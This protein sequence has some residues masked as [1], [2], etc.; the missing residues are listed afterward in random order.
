[1][2]L[3][4]YILSFLLLGLVFAIHGQ[5]YKFKEF[6]L[7]D[8]LPQDYIYCLA[9][10]HKGNLVIGTGE[11]LAIFNSKSFVQFDKKSGLENDFIQ[12]CITTR[13]GK[14]WLGHFDGGITLFNNSEFIKLKL[15]HI[16]HS[17]VEVLFET[18]DGSILAGTK[19]NGVLKINSNLKVE[20]YDDIIDFGINSIVQD[21]SGYIFIGTDEGIFKFSMDQDRLNLVKKAYENVSFQH[22]FFDKKENKILA[23]TKESGLLFID[24]ELE[25]GDFY[26]EFE[27]QNINQIVR[28]FE[29][30]YYI[31]SFGQGVY[32]CALKNDQ[33][34]ITDHYRME[35]G[36]SGDYIKTL[37]IDRENNIWMGSYGNGLSVLMN[38]LFSLYTRHDGLAEN[39][40]ISLSQYKNNL[41][42]ATERAISYLPKSGVGFH[43]LKIKNI[44]QDISTFHIKDSILFLG[45][46]DKGVFKI[47]L[48]DSSVSQW[49]Y[50]EDK[51]LQ[52]SIIDIKEDKLD[53]LW[54]AT[55]EGVFRA[56]K[57]IEGDTLF[58]RFTIEEGLAHNKIFSI[59]CDSRNRIWFATRG[60]GLSMYQNGKITTYPS[61][62]PGRSFDINCF[63]ED[64]L[65]G[66]WIGT[67]GQG[68][69]LFQNGK[70]LK[71]LD[72]EDGLKSP[73]CYFLKF[74]QK[75]H[76]WIGHQNG[77]SR[78]KPLQDKFTYYENSK[79]NIS[80]NIQTQ[81]CVKDR[82]GNLWIGSESGLLK[83]SPSA[84]KP[85]NFGPVVNLTGVLLNF[86]KTDW[87][88][89]T[90]SLTG[91]E[92]IPQ[93]LT[94]P[95]NKNHLTFNVMGVSLNP[96]A[97]N[98]IYQYKLNGFDKEWSLKTNEPFITYSNL[99]PGKYK[100]KVRA[101]TKNGKWSEMKNSFQFE[102]E[103]PFWQTWWF[104][105]C[106]AALGV[107]LIYLFVKIRTDQLRQQRERLKRDK[108]ILQ[109]EIDQRIIAQ[110]KQKIVEEK[111]KQTNQ[112][113]NNFIYRSSHDLRGP[114]STVKG[115][116]QL[117]VV[118]VKDPDA[119]KFFTMILDRTTVLDAV[120]KNLINIV[121]VI[122]GD[123]NAQELN[124]TEI[125]DEVIRELNEE[126]DLSPI[127]FKINIGEIV[128]YYN[129]FK[130]IKTIIFNI[131][132]NS[133]KY[134]KANF[135]SHI[136]LDISL[137]KDS[138]L[139]IKNI[140]NGLGI[141]P[142]IMPKIFDMFYRGSDESK[143]S[144]LGLYTVR[145]IV[146]KLNGSLKIDSKVNYSTTVNIS[147]PSFP[148]AP[149]GPKE[150][151]EPNPEELAEL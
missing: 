102:I 113:L 140:D 107:I 151:G 11:G 103:S 131:L 42:V 10:D 47:S 18:K 112:E 123:I 94:L 87:S 139:L 9:Q 54:I 150:I 79:I 35:T 133:V 78:L 141:S 93:N 27:D 56:Y 53:N 59:F 127:N 75:N 28:D 60:G 115:L 120:L 62:V 4:K 101:G 89:Y 138:N 3:K 80:G 16:S 51:N 99:P 130:L 134:R 145:K 43:K 83:Y 124:L 49:F 39:S 24:T 104:M 132:D 126:R 41:W 137:D 29:G 116:T 69:Y 68:I 148:E 95:Y 40:I 88:N 119:Q 143:G 81:A 5:S 26:Q 92:K 142:E 70:F 36:L 58:Q 129:D 77:L 66:L 38:P 117:G 100:L 64:D 136:F 21:S 61:P 118:E 8:G 110:E 84:D 147:I 86:Q 44:P 97:E 128:N 85:K 67:Y 121:E 13:K 149:L 125:T 37:Y 45:T 2:V 33:I 144:G 55:N 90:D 30:S 106:S 32:K 146:A 31:S 17:P 22:L 1:M 72:E 20:V 6:T 48:K 63:T 135:D 122:E 15:D 76:L 50:Q 7:K 105:T 114:I 25:N 19:S 46:I 52:N 111:L 74:D 82:S 91:I 96:D 12:S 57:D 65:G 109:A 71:K 14:L 108:E 23:G 98:I 73:Y 34:S